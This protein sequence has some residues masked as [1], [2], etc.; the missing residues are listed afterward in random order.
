VTSKPLGQRYGRTQRGLDER[1]EQGTVTKLRRTW[2][3]VQLDDGKV[4]S[5]MKGVLKVGDRVTVTSTVHGLLC[6]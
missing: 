3:T 2:A 6:T 5:V 1:E 4:I